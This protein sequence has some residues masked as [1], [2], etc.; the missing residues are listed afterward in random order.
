MNKSL[1]FAVSLLLVFV[2]GSLLSLNAL[3]MPFGD[4]PDHSASSAAQPLTA[5][6]R[7]LAMPFGDDRDHSASSAAQPL[8][9]DE[10]A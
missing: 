7:A 10:R 3:A 2:T 6:E 5:D 4:D 1:P 8:T 9:A